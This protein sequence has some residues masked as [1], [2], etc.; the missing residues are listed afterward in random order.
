MMKEERD[1]GMLRHIAI[2][3]L[4]DNSLDHILVLGIGFLVAFFFLFFYFFVFV[5]RAKGLDLL[6]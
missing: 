4:L 5:L 3:F 2:L 1:N 6:I